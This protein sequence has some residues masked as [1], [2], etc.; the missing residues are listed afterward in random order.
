M[1]PEQLSGG[2][3][4]VKSDIYA[5]GLVLFEL[6]TGRRAFEAKTLNELVAAAP[7]R[8]DH[9]A[10]VGRPRSRSGD[11]ARDPALPRARSRAAAGIRARGRGGAARRRSAGGGARGRRNAVAGNGGGGRRNRAPA[12]GRRPCSAGGDLRWRARRR[13]ALAIAC[14]SSRR[15][16]STKASEVLA[17]RAQEIV[18]E[19]G[20]TERPADTAHGLFVLAAI[21]LAAVADR[22]KHDAMG[23]AARRARFRRCASGIAPARASSTPIGDQ[24][25]C[26]RSAIPDDA[27]GHGGR[28][29]DTRGR[30]IAV[31]RRPAAGRTAPTT[32]RAR[33]TGRALFEAAG[34]PMRRS[35]RSSRVG[36]ERLRRS[37]GRR[38]KARCP[39]IRRSRCR[40]EAAAYQGRP[41]FF[42]IVGPVDAAAAHGT[43]RADSGVPL[44]AIRRRRSSWCSAG[45]AFAL[46]RHNLRSG[47]GDRRGAT[48][49]SLFV[50]GAFIAA[51]VIGARHSLQS[52]EE[53]N[54]FLTFLALALLN[55]G[56]L[57]LAYVAL[58]PYVRRY[59]PEILMSWTRLL[60]GRFRDPRVG[61]DILVGIAAGVVVALL[62]LAFYLL[63]PLV[64]NPP[65][66]PRGVNLQ[67]LLGTR[68]GNLAALFRMVPN[69]A[70][71]RDAA[72]RSF[73][74]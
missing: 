55:A 62:R 60:G 65:P 52:C 67:F 3:A 33:R 49:V 72:S 56:I 69:A 28:H 37:C 45:G 10:L 57:W 53:I 19:L 61:R 43:G 31:A 14:C 66:M 34:L 54:T 32:G 8:H 21:T 1:A 27:D 23:L 24:S 46:A 13:R 68:A 48:R 41:G 73:S 64:G 71:K 70:S 38:G 2:Q 50:L 22:S 40:A 51:W 16:R 25:P 26:R 11:R 59:C 4:S 39:D 30:L 42:Q 74:S 58:E 18:G 12:A 5:L 9:D 6:F 44:H 35:R 17:D 36:P 7:E 29:P 63:P 47:R 15:F 20:Y